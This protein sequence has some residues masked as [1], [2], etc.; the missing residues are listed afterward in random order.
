MAV[1]SRVKGFS[2]NGT[3]V[4]NTL[5]NG[6]YLLD[7]NKDA[8]AEL[9][10]TG[11]EIPNRDGTLTVSNRYENKNITVTVGIYATTVQERRNIERELIKNM[12]GTEGKLVFLDEPTFFL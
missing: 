6:I 10:Y 4:D 11:F 1:L 7:V 9:L 5:N 8:T 12:V 3:V 2:F